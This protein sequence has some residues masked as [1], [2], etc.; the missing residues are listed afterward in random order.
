MSITKKRVLLAVLLTGALL[1]GVWWHLTRHV[2][3]AMMRQG[4]LALL[5][6]A[7]AAFAEYYC[8]HQRWP[9]GPPAEI[10][11]RLAGRTEEQL[12]EWR[13]AQAR[14]RSDNEHL[15]ETIRRE[16]AIP[17]RNYLRS[18]NVKAESDELV[19]AWAHSLQFDLVD[20]GSRPSSLT[21]VGPDGRLGTGDDQSIALT[22]RP[23]RMT[24][25]I[26]SFEAVEHRRRDQE[27]RAAEQAMRR[28]RREAAREAAAAARRAP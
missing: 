24:P 4:N 9:H 28:A 23:R 18:Y 8:D 12:A 13:E 19:D 5:G 26:A 20:D 1:V 3:P 27:F 25:T 7:A 17:V 2:L 15:A 6:Q 11:H 10:F 14:P 21:S 16:Q 22:M